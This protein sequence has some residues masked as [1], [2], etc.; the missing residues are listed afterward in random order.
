MKTNLPVRHRNT[1]PP[2]VDLDT[3][4]ARAARGN[5]AAIEEIARYLRPVL[6]AEARDALTKG[7]PLADAE[8]IAHDLFVLLLAGTTRAMRRPARAFSA[9]PSRARRGPGA[10]P[11]AASRGSAAS[12]GA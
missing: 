1:E 2:R 8:D 6:V 9:P 3:L 10:G 12:C 5:R 11:R 7:E 4:I